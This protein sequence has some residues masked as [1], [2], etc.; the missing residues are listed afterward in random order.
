MCIRDS[1]KVLLR[2]ASAKVRA[3]QGEDIIFGVD[4]RAQH[5]VVL[6]EPHKTLSLI[7]IYQAAHAL[8]GDAGQA[9]GIDAANGLGTGPEAFE[10]DLD[11]R[12]F[13]QLQME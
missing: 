4:D 6:L 5:P 7:H 13:V 9:H 1:H 3:Q 2:K 11:I 12:V 10:A 8:H